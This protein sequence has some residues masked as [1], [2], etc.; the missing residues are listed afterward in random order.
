MNK[1]IWEMI[2]DYDP[3]SLLV[4]DESYNIQLINPAFAKTFNFGD[5]DV[6]G[7]SV[8]EFFDDIEDFV[9]VNQ[10]GKC[11][12]KIK[13]YPKHGLIMSEAVF[14]LEDKGLLVKI[15]HDVTSEERK[16]QELRGLKLQIAE[17][18]QKIVDKQMSVGQEIASILGETTAETKASLLKLL[19]ILKKEN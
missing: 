8:V 16:E 6:I 3:N 17:E 15:F 1:N 2:F 14:K 18:V 7:R 9:D 10:N 19:A 5:D 11:V 4:L 12:K 13:E